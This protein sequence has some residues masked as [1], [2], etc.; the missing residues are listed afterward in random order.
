VLVC[1]EKLEEACPHGLVHL[2]DCVRLAAALLPEGAHGGYV[3]VCC[4]E[5]PCERREYPGQ[6]AVLYEDGGH[7]SGDA[8]A[9]AV[10]AAHAY[11]AAAKRLSGDRDGRAALALHANLDGVGVK[12]LVTAALG[13]GEAKARLPRQLEGAPHSNVCR[14]KPQNARDE[15]AVGPVAKVRARERVV[16]D[17]VHVA[18]GRGRKRARYQRDSQRTCGVRG[19]RTHHDGAKHLER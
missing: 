19:G 18:D 11:A 8:H 9:N 2:E 14:S 1:A 15:C 16:Q 6:V 7:V 10:D 17:K 5:R 3:H 12:P 13:D 4:R